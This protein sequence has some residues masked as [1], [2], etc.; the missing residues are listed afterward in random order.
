MPGANATNAATVHAGPTDDLYLA[1]TAKKGKGMEK[2]ALVVTPTWAEAGRVTQAIRSSLKSEEKLGEER[3][4]DVWLPAHL[5]DPEKGDATHLEPGELLKFHKPAPGYQNGSRL[6]LAEG[7]KPPVEYAE[8]FEVYR[9][10]HQMLA[11]GDRMRINAGG[12]TK[13][14]KH[15]LRNGAFYTCHGFTEHGDPI[16]DHGWVVDKNWGHWSLG[17]AST[18]E[19]SQAKT[20]SKVLV[21]L[22]SEAFGV[23]NQRR[24]YVPAIRGKEQC[25]VFTDD[26][27]GLLKAVQKP[28][29]PL[30][31]TELAEAA[32]RKPPLKERLRR[33]LSFMRRWGN[34]AMWR[35]KALGRDHAP[36]VERD[37]RYGR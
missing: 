30:S 21:S 1:A 36:D 27:Q 22:P 33:H 2:T 28:D 17:Y 3:P 24:L 11:V 6:V 35:R 8:R 20:V 7:Q 5:T 13:D 16:I 10:G 32:R 4:F 23:A 18:S 29:Q 9:P 12:V 26:K 14:G 34:F 25:L 15:K 37:M 19:G 31:A